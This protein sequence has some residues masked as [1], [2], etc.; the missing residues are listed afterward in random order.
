MGTLVA[1]LEVVKGFAIE[2][3]SQTILPKFVPKALTCGRDMLI[4]S[5]G[6]DRDDLKISS[7]QAQPMRELQRFPLK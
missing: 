4:M 1:D 6:G 5:V 2:A 7:F 3:A